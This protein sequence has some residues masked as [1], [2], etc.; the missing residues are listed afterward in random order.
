MAREQ[1][2]RMRLDQALVVRR[3][4]P[5]RSRARDMIARGCVTV[6][7]AIIRKSGHSIFEHAVIAVADEA[8][9]Y[10]SRGGLKLA[11]ALAAFGFD[12]TGRTA[13]DVGA[14]TGGFTDVLLKARAARV[15]AVD[16][17]R[18]Q[19]HPILR[20]DPRVVS[21]EGTDARTLSREQIPEVIHAIVADVS[22]IA[23]TKALPVP[24]SFA[25]AG[26]WLVVL[27]KPQF[28]AGRSAVGK[29]GIVRDPG[30]RA[31]A[32]AEVRAWLEAQPGWSVVGIIPSPVAGGS[33]NEEFLI[34]ALKYE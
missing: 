9:P 24:L 32:V 23:A 34:G 8:N 28:E 6:D 21:L 33:G 18:D 29:G 16:I 13:L 5:T 25:E 31:Q 19:L 15:Y 11:A 1:F 30:H 10:V 14:S 22:F 27:V 2:K 7:G 17:G 3:L 12:A 20:A 4:A 26:A